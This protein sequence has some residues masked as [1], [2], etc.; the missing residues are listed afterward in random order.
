MAE[1]STV[2]RYRD[3]DPQEI[4]ELLALFQLEISITE[5]KRDI[6]G[7]YW[8]GEE[9]GMIGNQ[10]YLRTDTPIHSILHECSH[11]ICMDNERRISLHTNA[12]S[13][14]DEENAV[15]YLQVLLAQKLPSIS[16]ERLFSDM[17]SW[18]YSFRLGS[19]KNWYLEDAFEARDWLL[20]NRLINKQCLPLLHLRGISKR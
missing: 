12:Y 17:D 13:D 7:S 11:Y 3:I 4:A 1:P 19:T 8:G 10:L 14:D 9:A 15:C 6:P 5:G 20:K 2:L 18:G 16:I